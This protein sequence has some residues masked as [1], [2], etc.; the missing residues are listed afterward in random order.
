MNYKTQQASRKR[1]LY[2]NEG[3]GTTPEIGRK[4]MIT[5][6][7]GENVRSSNET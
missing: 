2:V 7:M 5:P 3:R 1:K 6:K 4:L